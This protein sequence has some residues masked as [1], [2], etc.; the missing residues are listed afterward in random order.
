MKEGVRTAQ[1]DIIQG[2]S[3]YRRRTAELTEQ[4]LA[5]KEDENAPAVA[6][7]QGSADLG[8]GVSARQLDE[9]MI[10]VGSQNFSRDELSIPDPEQS[11]TQHDL[12]SDFTPLGWS[13]R[14]GTG[15]SSLFIAAYDGIDE[16]D[17]PREKILVVKNAD[18]ALLRVFA[19]PFENRIPVAS[20]HTAAAVDASDTPNMFE[21]SDSVGEAE[22]EL[23]MS[24]EKVDVDTL[25]VGERNFSH[26]QFMRLIAP[27]TRISDDAIGRTEEKISLHYDKKEWQCTLGSGAQTLSLRMYEER[28]THQKIIVI[29]DN[30]GKIRGELFPYIFKSPN[31]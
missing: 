9:N 23:G 11:L 16:G 14:L 5:R 21:E 7:R 22:L 8:N 17:H 25:R 31:S 13:C 28:K 29:T 20:P 26:A 2:L 10:S 4:A 24:V 27:Q 30:T 6:I 1:E 18:G 15:K 19:H 12:N 3:L